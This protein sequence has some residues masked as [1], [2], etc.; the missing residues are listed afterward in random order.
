M[1]KK[2]QNTSFICVNCQQTVQ[3]LQNGSYRNHCPFCLTSLHVDNKPGDRNSPCQGVMLPQKLIR[4]G[5]KGW[6]VVHKCKK[7][8]EEKVN[9]IAEGYPQPDN[10]T[11]LIQLSLQD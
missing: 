6:Q 11:I 1:S 7:C 3:P 9:K 4:H 5:K 2:E 8:G 10:W